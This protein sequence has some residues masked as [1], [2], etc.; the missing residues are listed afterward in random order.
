[1]THCVIPAGLRINLLDCVVHKLSEPTEKGET[2]A[3]VDHGIQTT[4]AKGSKLEC[5]KYVGF[6]GNEEE[7]YEDMVLGARFGDF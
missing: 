5:H 6:V 1:M 7:L 2:H 3:V 4:V